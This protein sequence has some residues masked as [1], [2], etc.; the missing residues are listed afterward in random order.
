MTD[1]LELRGLRVMALCGALPEERE[2]AQPFE[3][4]IDV[5]TDLSVAGK[6]DNLDDTL[7]YG[8]LTEAISIVL[9]GEQY[10][11]LERMA[12]RVTEIVLDAPTVEKVVVS[13]HKL[14]PPVSEH[15]ATAGVRIE[16]TRS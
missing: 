4:D 2:R 1:V 7:D 10:T 16:R 12:E 9:H 11:L 14:R 15:L 13:V 6:S 8:S 5:H 3:L